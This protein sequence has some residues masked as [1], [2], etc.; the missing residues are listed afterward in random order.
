MDE[1]WQSKESRRILSRT[2]SPDTRSVI[3]ATF[4]VR[5]MQEERPHDPDRTGADP[6]ENPSFFPRRYVDPG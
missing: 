6:L 1:R 2:L 5:R 4:V 3:G